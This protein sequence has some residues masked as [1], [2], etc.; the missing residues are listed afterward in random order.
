MM[1]QCPD[2]RFANYGEPC[3]RAAP[4]PQHE[5]VSCGNGRYCP[6]NTKCGRNGKSCLPKDMVDCGSYAC[7]AGNKCSAGGGCVPQ[8]AADCGGG[9]YCGSG[10]VCL[11]ID[12]CGTQ[13]QADALR[14]A[15]KL[16]KDEADK[17]AEEAK[18]LQAEQQQTAR[19]Q[20]RKADEDRNLTL[21]TQL[22]QKLKE[23]QDRKQAAQNPSAASG[24]PSP[25]PSPA[26]AAVVRNVTLSNGAVV[27]ID[28]K[29]NIVSGDATAGRDKMASPPS[30]GPAGLVPPSTAPDHTVSTTSTQPKTGQP[31]SA[32]AAPTYT[33]APTPSGTIEVFQNGQRIGTG[34]AQY[35]AQYGYR[36]T[37]SALPANPAPALTSGTPTTPSGAVVDIASGKLIFAPPAT[38]S[39]SNTA[40][41]GAPCT[42][43]GSFDNS[44]SSS[45]TRCGNVGT[46]SFSS[47]DSPA[48]AAAVPAGTWKS[49]PVSAN[50]PVAPP[51]TTIQTTTTLAL[52]PPGGGTTNSSP[53]AYPTAFADPRIVSD[54]QKKVNAGETGIGGIMIAARAVSDENL[55]LLQMPLGQTLVDTG[56][57]AGG[58]FVPKPLSLGSDVVT[59]A[60]AASDA[61]KGDYLAAAQQSV[62][63]GT[64][65]TT[66]AL[67]AALMP[68]IP[69]LGEAI[70][71]AAGQTTIDAGKFVVAPH[72]GGWLFEGDP[73]FFTPPAASS[74]IHV[75]PFTNKPVMKAF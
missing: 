34:T 20:I 73:S 47:I 64:V 74:P 62:D 75:D 12:K 39:G 71:S 13:Q 5:G 28:E 72:I 32:T 68:A 16:K 69:A 54:N 23:I 43:W 46:G 49:V 4:P 61:W 67:G 9:H 59:L 33:F 29:G 41:N 45:G 52:Q 25:S 21:K 30:L 18:R 7:K 3:A 38:G 70:G 56:A 22:Q 15:E 14:A 11:G 8:E 19:D 36:G 24:S 2:G 50:N 35:A 48:P 1:C 53:V 42:A 66:G 58:A 26:P 63:W 37:G 57:A 27:G 31:S 60:T 17:V 6:Q 10:L 51:A 40:A 55:K 44:S 65:K